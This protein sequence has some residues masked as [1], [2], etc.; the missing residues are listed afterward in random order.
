MKEVL[1]PPG[2]RSE[3]LPQLRR[4]LESISQLKELIGPIPEF[5]IV[6]DANILIEEVRWRQIKRRNR[7]ARSHLEECIVAGTIVGYITPA[8][9]NEVEEKL[10]VLACESGH[11]PEDWL[12]EWENY[13]TLFRIEEPPQTEIAGFIDGQDPDDA[14]TLALA[15]SVSACGILSRDSDIKAM[16]GRVIPVAFVLEARDYSRRTAITATIKIGGY[17]LATG[18]GNALQMLI[19]TLK[20]GTTWFQ[21]L[22]E[23]IKIIIVAALIVAALHPKSRDAVL[24][25]LKRAGTGLTDLLPSIVQS[26]VYL[27]NVVE[28]NRATPPTLPID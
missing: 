1:T 21:E 13:R 5:H 18:I 17:V 20:R 19:P 7:A 11:P 22:P 14:P 25:C 8:V 15:K 27:A 12:A 2:L 9:V 26:M 10:S 3:L 6:V 4:I 28:Q 23:G 16:G 24:A